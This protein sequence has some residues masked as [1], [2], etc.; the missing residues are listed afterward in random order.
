MAKSERGGKGAFIITK[1]FNPSLSVFATDGQ[2]EWRHTCIA[3]L[4]ENTAAHVFLLNVPITVIYT[5]AR[6]M[7]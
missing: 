5:A 7:T 1:Y 3:V 2:N 4:V 6:S